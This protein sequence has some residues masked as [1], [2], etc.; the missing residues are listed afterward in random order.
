MAEASTKSRFLSQI[1]AAAVGA[2][3]ATPTPLSAR[4]RAGGGSERGGVK[5]VRARTPTSLPSYK[6]AARA[7]APVRTFLA[8]TKAATLAVPAAAPKLPA[9]AACAA[10]ADLFSGLF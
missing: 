6:F 8:P 5:K 1:G 3:G 10:V 2:A 7:A 9:S 4:R